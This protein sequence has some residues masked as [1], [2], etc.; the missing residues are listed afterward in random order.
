ME[1]KTPNQMRSALIIGFGG[2]GC[3]HAQSLLS[4]NSFDNIFIIEPN[5]Q[6]Y[7]S[8]CKLIGAENNTTIQRIFELESIDKALEIV[9]IATLAD[10]RFKYFYDVIKLKPKFLLLEKVIFQSNTDF[11]KAKEIIA[12]GKTKVYGNLPNRYFRNYTILKS[13]KQQIQSM[14]VTGPD[15]GLL[16]NAI[17]YI[18]LFQ[19]LTG[20]LEIIAENSFGFTPLKNKRGDQFLES[21]G[22]LRFKTQ[23]DIFLEIISDSR[24]YKD[25]VVEID[26]N[27]GV[28]RFNETS[29]RGSK[30][31]NTGSEEIKLDLIY[32]SILTA[33][34]YL[35]ME[36]GCCTM[37]TLNE[38]SSTHAVLFDAIKLLTG[39]SGDF[40]PIT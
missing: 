36:N 33:Q 37:P 25:V 29:L 17:H 23:D 32:S 4:L 8:N 24:V 9:V 18:D 13:K 15:F 26:T 28:Y 35:D 19:F 40:L 7:T 14:R 1:I 3:R 2:M 39:K 22:T 5:E 10:V 21:E 30:L 20:S 38:L 34:V 27:K 6:T 16:C 31:N 12:Q 11:V